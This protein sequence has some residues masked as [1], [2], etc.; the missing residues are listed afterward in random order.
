MAS[1]NKVL[2]IGN[3]GKDPEERFFGDGTP[4]TNLSVACTEKYKDKQGEQ[5]E[6][7]EWVNVVF[8]GKL[9]EIA[10]KYLSKGSSVYVEGK[11]KTEKYTDK[12]GIE[13]YATKVIGSSMQILKGK[14]REETASKPEKPP[15]SS[16]GLDD[17]IP[18]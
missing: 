2:I 7:T 15:V 18:F 16:D 6:L 3:L 9:A 10:G 17:D 8:F 5:K 11:L 1:L 12:Q 4:V 14:P 13:R